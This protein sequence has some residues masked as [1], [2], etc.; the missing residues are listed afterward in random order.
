M[1]KIKDHNREDME[2]V[3]L[4]H[5]NN[6]IGVHINGELIISLH[7]NGVVNFFKRG[8]TTPIPLRWKQ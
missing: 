3:E 1:L 2:D 4:R 6:G 8:S 7:H 5:N